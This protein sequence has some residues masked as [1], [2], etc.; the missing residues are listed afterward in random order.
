MSQVA[1]IVLRGLIVGLLVLAPALLLPDISQEAAQGITLLALVAAIVVSTEY[2]A[3]YPGLIE[4]RDAKPYNRIRFCLLASIVLCVTILQRDLLLPPEARSLI[5][6]VAYTLATTMDFAFSPVRLLVVALPGDLPTA[7]LALVMA[8]AS[9]SYILSIVG[10][11]CFLGLL[12]GGYWPRRNMTLNVWVNLPNFDPTKG[13][14]VVHR[15]ERDGHVNIVLG[16]ILPFSLPV[17]LHISALLVQPMTLQAPLTF[18]WGVSLWAF[19]PAS[20]IMRGV[21]MYRVAQMI[22]AQRRRIAEE[23]ESLPL[24]ARSAYS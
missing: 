11:V 22:R 5:S 13:H 7:H 9:L 12:L 3:A 23:E 15:L 17:L 20:L 24:P 8:A 6:T 21:A 2:A 19:I 16:I 1:Q 18:V 10:L 4:F 14:D